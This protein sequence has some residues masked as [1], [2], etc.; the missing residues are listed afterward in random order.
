[1]VLDT[2]VQKPFYKRRESCQNAF[3]T[4]ALKKITDDLLKL[5]PEERISVAEALIASVPQFEDSASDEAWEKELDKR[6]NAYERGEAETLS[7]EESHARAL[8]I[9]HEGRRSSR[10]R[11]A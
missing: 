11:D 10:N 2:S 9:L 6:L 8:S 1:M 4:A 5:P 3:V 7:S